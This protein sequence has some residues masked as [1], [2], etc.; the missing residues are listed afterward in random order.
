MPKDEGGG[1]CTRTLVVWSLKKTTHFCVCLPLPDKNIMIENQGTLYRRQNKGLRWKFI[2]KGTFYRN[3][4]WI[5]I[6]AFGFCYHWSINLFIQQRN[7]DFHSCSNIFWQLNCWF[8]NVFV[9]NVLNAR[10]VL[11][12]L[13]KQITVE[14][15]RYA[16]KQLYTLTVNYFL[17]SRTKT[18]PSAAEAPTLS[19]V[20]FQQ[21]SN[22]PPVPV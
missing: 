13:K 3:I 19:P 11:W 18:V 12:L 20:E 5:F 16:Q 1:G 14:T 4:D 8:S 10:N 7:L 9:F 21:T 6:I 2:H 17:R 15:F 22:I